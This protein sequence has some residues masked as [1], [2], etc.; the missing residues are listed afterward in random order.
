MIMKHKNMGNM[1]EHL[2]QIVMGNNL[3]SW[4]CI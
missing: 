4:D 2:N 1:K 3:I